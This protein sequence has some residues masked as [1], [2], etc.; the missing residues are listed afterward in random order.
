MLPDFEVISIAIQV[1]PMLD[2]LIAALEGEKKSKRL[3]PQIVPQVKVGLLCQD[4]G[5]WLPRM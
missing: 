3:P 5:S 4:H 1:V 2:R